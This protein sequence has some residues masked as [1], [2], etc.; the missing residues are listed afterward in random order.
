[1]RASAFAATIAASSPRSLASGLGE[2]VRVA[3][4]RPRIDDP[5]PGVDRRDS[6]RDVSHI[7]ASCPDAGIR[8]PRRS[9]QGFE[10][11]TEAPGEGEVVDHV[12]VPLAND[13]RDLDPARRGR[14]AGAA[15]DDGADA[16]ELGNVGRPHAELAGGALGDDVHGLAAVRDVAMHAHAVAEM[17]PLPIDE[18][19]RIEAS[20]QRA[21]TVV[22]SGGGVGGLPFEVHGEPMRRERGVRE[23]VAVEGVEHH[24][25]I[26]PLER[27]RLEEPDLA[28]SSLLGRRAEQHDLAPDSLDDAR[29]GEERTD[30]CGGDQVVTAG[31]P[32]LRERVVLGE[33][34]HAR[35]ARL[36]GAGP[37]RG[38]HPSDASLDRVASRGDKLVYPSSRLAPPRSEA[39]GWRE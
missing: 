23:D 25:G 27:S 30:P 2:R 22:G 7:R 17:D 15:L 32:N 28:P 24:G 8:L 18:A 4:R 16:P 12:L 3:E 31:M 26:D 5:E 13:D 1:M 14:S 19:E 10:V 29:C 20:R 6:V 35:A 38:L 21:R 39:P 34:R 37:Q 33:D 36:T 9:P 11:R